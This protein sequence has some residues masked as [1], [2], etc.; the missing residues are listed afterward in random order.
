MSLKCPVEC[1]LL[2]HLS[3]VCD[4]NRLWGRL[5]GCAD[6]DVL[7]FENV[8]YDLS[9]FPA[10]STLAVESSHSALGGPLFGRNFDFPSFGFLNNYS[11]LIVYRPEGKHA[12]VS[13]SAR[14]RNWL[15]NCARPSRTFPPS[16]GAWSAK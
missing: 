12:F 16:S 5:F 10:C 14:L 7:T 11:L 9:R 15:R 2:D 6:L 4:R 1:S 8:V 3:D 13:S